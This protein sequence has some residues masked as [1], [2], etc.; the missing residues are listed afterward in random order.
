MWV[1]SPLKHR[2]V[3]HNLTF[4]TAQHR[5]FCYIL[6]HKHRT[7]CIFRRKTPHVLAFKRSEVP[8]YF[9][10]FTHLNGALGVCVCLCVSVCVYLYIECS[11]TSFYLCNLDSFADFTNWCVPSCWFFL[12]VSPALIYFVQTFFHSPWFSWYPSFDFTQKF[13][14]YFW[15]FSPLIKVL[16]CNS[17]MY[18]IL[19]SYLRISSSRRWQARPPNFTPPQLTAYSKRS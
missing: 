6:P 15:F 5:T 19:I 8:Q 10:F 9:A 14:V 13:V 1:I 3:S 16:H 4:S 2:T 7:F 18:L 12:C 17:C 11:D